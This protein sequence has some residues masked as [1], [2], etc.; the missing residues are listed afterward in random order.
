VK[1][2]VNTVPFHVASQ[3]AVGLT[4]GGVIYIDSRRLRQTDKRALIRR[5]TRLVED[6]GREDWTCREGPLQGSGDA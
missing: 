2:D 1:W 6:H 4:H 5:L 3:L